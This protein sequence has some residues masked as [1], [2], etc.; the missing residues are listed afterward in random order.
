MKMKTIWFVVIL[1]IVTTIFINLKFDNNEEEFKPLEMNVGD[2][3]EFGDYKNT[4]YVINYV[5]G[6]VTGDNEKE[7]IILVGEKEDLNSEHAMNV[8]VVVYDTKNKSFLKAGIK[9]FEG[10]GAKI[11]LAELTND[12][13]NEIIVCLENENK[14]RSI[15]ILENK[16]NSIKEIFGAK[17]NNGI[18]F[19]GEMVDGVKA[20]V[21]CNKLNK[22]L[23]IDLANEKEELLRNKNIDESGKIIGENKKINTTGFTSMDIVDL[24]NQKGIQTTQLITAFDEKHIVDEVIVIWKYEEGKWQIKEAK[25]TRMGNL[26]Y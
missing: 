10:K 6:D 23:Y 4:M 9:K 3:F 2:V 7:M 25:G 17:E 15:R 11:F 14:E 13:V 21:K 18:K 20:H 26:I 24:N 19:V 22:E 1:I 16:N 5:I 12:G 8:D